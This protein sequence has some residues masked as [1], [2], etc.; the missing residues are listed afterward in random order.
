M[1]GIFGL[2]GAPRVPSS[3]TP[4]FPWEDAAG[5]DRIAAAIQR[6]PFAGFSLTC[7]K[8]RSIAGMLLAWVRV[9]REN[10]ESMRETKSGI[11]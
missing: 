6:R 3:A 1:R 7:E 8:P 5:N 11:R 2:S 4:P 10:D 9:R